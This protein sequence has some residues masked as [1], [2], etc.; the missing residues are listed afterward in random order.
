MQIKTRHITVFLIIT[1][2]GAAI[3]CATKQSPTS[4]D[5]SFRSLQGFT[6]GEDTLFDG[7]YRDIDLSALRKRSGG[8]DSGDP[9]QLNSQYWC[10]AVSLGETTHPLY[11]VM[12]PLYAWLDQ[13]SLE[14]WGVAIDLEAHEHGEFITYKLVK[15]DACY[16]PGEEI[17]EMAICYTWKDF[18][19]LPHAWDIG[20]T[21]LRWVEGDFPGEPPSY[22]TWDWDISPGDGY[23]PD[24]AYDF[25]TG[26]LYITYVKDV[27]EPGYNRWLHY[28]RYIRDAEEWSDEQCLVSDGSPHD[29]YNPRIDVGIVKD[30]HDDYS[31][32]VNIVGIVYS[33]YGYNETNEY[34]LMGVYWAATEADNDS[35]WDH[36]WCAVLTGVHLPH[37]DIAFDSNGINY[38][39]VVYTK[40]VGSA[41]FYHVWEADN[42]GNEHRRIYRYPDEPSVQATIAVNFKSSTDEDDQRASIGF[43]EGHPSSSVWQSRCMLIDTYSGDYDNFDFFNL[44]SS[45][46]G[47]WTTDILEITFPGVATAILDKSSNDLWGGYC[48]WFDD[49]DDVRA[50]YGNPEP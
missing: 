49:L 50:C 40:V 13:D 26:D 28:R 43:F 27:D 14:E 30:I 37:I 44:N 32:D 6:A 41:P 2:V 35:K 10:A 9:Q 11:P 18:L 33:G 45:I 48:L 46:E 36:T 17:I 4:P 22:S 12:H 47:T 1:L 25:K 8:S 21:I 5:E 24:I 3:G 29:A 16:F 38:Y 19:D 23:E 34:D 20:V 42:L 39:G 31:G 15:V 7:F